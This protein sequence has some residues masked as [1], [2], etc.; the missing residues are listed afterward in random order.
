[1]ASHLLLHGTAGWLDLRLGCYHRD[2]A[3]D[4]V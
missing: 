2:A 1:M 4:D 3:L